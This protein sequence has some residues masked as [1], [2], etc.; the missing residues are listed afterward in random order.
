MGAAPTGFD[1]LAQAGAQSGLEQNQHAR[2]LQDEQRQQNLQRNWSIL[3]DPN[4]A[5]ELKQQAGQDIQNQYPT[6]EHKGTFLSDIL[7]IHSKQPSAQPI[8]PPPSPQSNPISGDAGTPSQGAKDELGVPYS[9]APPAQAAPAA[10]PTP[11]QAPKTPIA[12]VQAAGAAPTPQAAMD[13]WKQY[14]GPTAVNEDIAETR[15]KNAAG[16][17]Q[18]LADKN[19]AA[20]IE[21]A[22]IRATGNVS[23]QKLNAAAQSLG[24]DDFTSATP[25]Q[26][27]AAMKALHSATITPGYKVIQRGNDLVAIDSHNSSDPGKI[28]GHKDDVV[29]THTLKPRQNAD[30]STELVPVTTYTQKGSSQPILETADDTTPVSINTPAVLGSSQSAQPSQSGTSVSSTTPQNAPANP[31][32]RTAGTKPTGAAVKGASKTLT[33]SVS[34]GG[35]FPFGSKPNDLQKSDT[36][37]YTKLAEDSNAKQEALASATEAARSPSPSSDQQL[38]YSWVRSNVQGAGRMT[39]QEFNQATRIGSFGQK[40]SNWYSMASTGKITPEIRNMLLSDIH[41]SAKTSQGLA[42]DARS[43]VQ[44]DMTPGKPTSAKTPGG[45]GAWTAPKDAPAAPKEDGKLLK[46]NGQVIAKSQGGNWVRP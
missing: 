27:M 32:A 45:P 35:A 38:I 13:L 6:P 42:D 34:V 11:Q 43:R 12:A 17:A 36:A 37:Q 4:S 41:R 44:Q 10:A 22:H 30:G 20:R 29:V 46:I 31:G 28:I 26:K 33:P 9:S 16:F 39:Q 7:H 2:Q 5:H 14:R 23:M 15:A 25:E 24:A 3:N 21:E 19:N 8:P 1:L 18:T 40:V